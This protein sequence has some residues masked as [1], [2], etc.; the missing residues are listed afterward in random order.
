MKIIAINGSPRKNKNT[1]TL[2]NKA[3]EGAKSQGSEIEL[4]NL[5]DLKYRG[6]ISCFACKRK[7]GEHGRCAMKDDLTHVLEKLKT[8]DAII[9]GSPIYNMNITS[10]MSALLERF[11]FSNVI[12]ST[13]IPTVYPR[14]IQSGFIYTMGITEKYMEDTGYKLILK[15]HQDFISMVLGNPI[16]LL[17]SYDTYQFTDY[18]KYESSMFSEKEKAKHRDEQFPIDCQKAFDM[19]VS[20]AINV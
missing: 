20:L 6:C 17:Y 18:E 5:Y 1:I 9:F 19:G 3:L 11:I 10:G 4:I 13:E 16:K 14:K 7:N 12:Y 15:P 8:A 2:L